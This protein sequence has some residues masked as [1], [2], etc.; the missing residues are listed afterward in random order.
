MAVV[1]KDLNLK[2]L[3]LWFIVAGLSMSCSK[4][5]T[6]STE[7]KIL[8]ENMTYLALGDSY[9]I[10]E[11]VPENLR[12]PE[13]LVDSL[14]AAGINM[15]SPRII[16]RTGWTTDE[17]KNAI[18][19]SGLTTDSRFDMVTLLIGV[20]NQYRGRLVDTY[21]PEFTDL[22]NRAIQFAGGKKERVF[23][24]SIPDYAYTPFGKG[25]ANISKGIDE[26]NTENELITRKLGVTYINITP[27]SRE[28]LKTPSLVASDDLHP[29]G[30][31]YQ[32]WVNHILTSVLKVL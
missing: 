27:I 18:E 2:F 30:K 10:G 21:K 32:L 1:R 29:S 22:L 16:A 9:T 11:S 4:K 13:L 28:G 17:L 19:N 7:P 24:V 12:F 23:V 6:P 5:V 26:Y 25:N 8:M 3:Y 20:N 14:K 15:G 31:Q